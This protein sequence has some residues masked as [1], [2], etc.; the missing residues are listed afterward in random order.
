MRSSRSRGCSKRT[1]GDRGPPRAQFAH[2]LQP[3]QAPE[4]PAVLH[5][6]DRL[7]DGTW[8]QDT[9]LPWLIL[10]LTHSPIY[11]GAL[12]FARYAPFL[13]FGLFSGVARRPVRQPP[14][15]DR[16]AD[17]VDGRGAALAVLAFAGVVAAVAVLRARVPRRH[18]ARL[19]RAEPP[20]A[21]L[22]AGRP[23]RAAERD[24]AELV[25]LQRRPSGRPGGR[26]SADRRGRLRLVLRDQRRLVPRRARGVAADA[27]L[28]AL[29]GGAQLS[30]GEDRRRDPR[31]SALRPADARGAHRP[32]DGD[33]RQR[34]GIQL[35]RPAAG[36]HLE[37]A[38][39]GRRGLRRA[40][41]R[42]S[43]RA[44]WWERCSRR[45]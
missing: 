45:R 28:G 12:V 1:S 38:R 9:A 35:P 42:A 40:L 37:D 32:G 17:G 24:R 31:G 41:R 25:A 10:G 39:L 14:G 11:V 19:R 44:R 43:A 27:R 22:P 13:V 36:A 3:A 15:R 6:P 7:G 8:M 29:P 26:R 34:D 20:R 30:G 4:L 5:R 2:V 16:H 21:D 33:R 18:R 23:Q